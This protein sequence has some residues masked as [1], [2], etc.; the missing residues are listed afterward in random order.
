MIKK[1]VY[2]NYQP[3]TFKYY[4]DYYFEE[5]RANGFE[6]EYW[7]VSNLYFVDNKFHESNI[8][9]TTVL[10]ISSLK[11]LKSEILLVDRSLTLF[12]TNITY[13][14]SVWRLFY[15]LK[16][17]DCKLAFFARGMHPVP[18]RNVSS[19]F[20]QV[21][22]SLNLKRITNASKNRIAL[23]LKKY[24][25]IKTFDFVFRAG[26]K[27]DMT[28]G[29]GYQYDMKVSR[30]VEINYFDYDKYLKVLKEIIS[31]KDDYCVF[32]DV[33]LPFHPDIEMLGIKTVN[34]DNYYNNLNEYFDFIEK[35]YS[36]NVI[37]CAHPK[38]LKYQLENPFNGRQIVFNQ[39]CEFVKDAKFAITNYS[40]SI[41]F[42]IL[43]KKPI[44]FISS[45]EE[46]EKMFDLHETTLYLSSVLN[47]K[48][49]QFDEI[50]KNI[51]H[52]LFID[53]EIY[54][55][56]KYKYLTSIESEN[57]FSSEIF[58]ETISKM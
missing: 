46:K 35:T 8:F 9:N 41:S 42:P 23:F 10:K 39:T 2:I 27:G 12:V 18:E 7:D 1:I 43:F 51:V 47:C 21:I 19:K 36:L 4:S 40:S 57:R 13:E 52:D 55:D 32:L 29:I 44:L 34:A 6:V 26:S 24:K 54:D 28:I 53:E 5:C 3:I 31:F 58:I 17:L 45:K 37:I 48:V 33:Y 15:I 50:N 22:L 16:I 38:A 25:I 49:S 56:Y 11:E 30:V 14:F 20:F